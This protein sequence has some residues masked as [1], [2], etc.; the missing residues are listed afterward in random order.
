MVKKKTI[1]IP[2]SNGG[3]ISVFERDYKNTLKLID[4]IGVKQ[5]TRYISKEGLEIKYKTENGHGVIF[6][7]DQSI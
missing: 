5:V 1:Q 2:L 3:S 4:D 6:L 7:N